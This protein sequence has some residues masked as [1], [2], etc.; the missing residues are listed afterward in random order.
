MEPVLNGPYLDTSF[1]IDDFV[2]PMTGEDKV[3]VRL[4]A[5]LS[6]GMTENREIIAW[7]LEGT[8]IIQD[9]PLDTMP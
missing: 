5:R 1:W 8:Q 6:N 3:S 9:A 4:E 2:I 7:H